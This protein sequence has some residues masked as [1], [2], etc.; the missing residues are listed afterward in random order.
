[1]SP[2]YSLIQNPNEYVQSCGIENVHLFKLERPERPELDL[3]VDDVHNLSSTNI[4]ENIQVRKAIGRGLFRMEFINFL[5]LQRNENI[6]E[7]EDFLGLFF[8]F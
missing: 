6:P 7:G 1:M 5:K 2:I 4:E 8:F 3:L